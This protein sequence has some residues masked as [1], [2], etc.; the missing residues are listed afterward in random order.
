[1][2]L[3]D[4]SGLQRPWAFT[5]INNEI[6]DFYFDSSEFSVTKAA[7][8][9][10]RATFIYFYPTVTLHEKNSQASFAGDRNIWSI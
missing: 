6:L 3:K 1:M 4:V 7:L 2:T 10:S 9:L 5:L 8:L